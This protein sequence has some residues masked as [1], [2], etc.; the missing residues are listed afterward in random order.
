MRRRPP[1][2]PWNEGVSVRERNGTQFYMVKSEPGVYYDAQGREVEPSAAAAAGFP[3]EE[4]VRERVTRERLASA[5]ARI[6]REVHYEQVKLHHEDS[7]P[8]KAEH[9]GGGKWIVV[10]TDS[11]ETVSEIPKGDAA[12]ATAEAEALALSETLWM[13]QAGFSDEEIAAKQSGAG[14]AGGA[15]G[16]GPTSAGDPND[17]GDE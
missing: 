16:A 9:A 6:R 1:G 2:I 7:P 15:G 3:V 17:D 4:Q 13:R 10:N 11:G 14:S 8:F 5:E 12:R